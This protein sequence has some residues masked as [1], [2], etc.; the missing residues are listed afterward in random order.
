MSSP[1]WTPAGL[2][3]ELLPYERHVWRLV[4]GQHRVSTMKL[5]DSLEE[6]T[7]LEDLI[8]ATKPAIP[9][10]CRGF[11]YLL[12]SPFRYPPLPKGSRFRRPGHPGVFYAAEESRTAAAEKAFYQLLFFTESPDTPW[13]V[14][15]VE[16]TGFSVGVYS[17]R[18]L[19]LTAPP[20]AADAASWRDPVE[21]GPCQDLAA[22]A[23]QAQ[24]EILRYASARDPDGVCVAV[25]TCAA[26]AETAPKNNRETW[27]IGTRQS[28]AYAI[29]ES[30]I[31]AIQFDREAFAA[32][33]RIAKMRWE[34]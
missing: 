30:P 20:L 34:R 33:P 1:I 22:A 21:Y 10:E 8:E 32:D 31:A 14:N 26:F 15:P 5:V 17:P 13:P 9:P 12:F 16:H 19:D 11:D 28:G 23:R 3:S 2:P 7:V 6:Q 4:E 29:R 24:A 25:L 18:A 27:W